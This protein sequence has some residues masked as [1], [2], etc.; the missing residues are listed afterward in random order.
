MPHHDFEIL[1]M[2][3]FYLDAP[4]PKLLIQCRQAVGN[5]LKNTVSL[6]VSCIYHD[7]IGDYW[8]ID[9]KKYTA[10]KT[11]HVQLSVNN[12]LLFDVAFGH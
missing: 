11:V 4:L 3:M 6:H 2:C 8:A 7:A 9:K 12:K 1:L 10:N 5:L